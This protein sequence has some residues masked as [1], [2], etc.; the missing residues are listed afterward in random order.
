MPRRARNPQVIP[1]PGNP[2]GANNRTDLPA[3]PIRTVS[4]GVHG[5]VKAQRDAQRAMPLALD[6]NM[7]AAP[8]GGG[9][10]AQLPIAPT[11]L[12]SPSMRPNEALATMPP[13]DPDL[14]DLGQWA[15]TL[16]ELA[17]YPTASA[18]LRELA[19][20]AQARFGA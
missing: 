14:E 2:P 5:S 18:E 16:I 1:V 17:S 3:Q 15:G 20:R 4:G 9:P 8:G 11:P 13:P 10:R 19:A 6:P 7:P 12:M